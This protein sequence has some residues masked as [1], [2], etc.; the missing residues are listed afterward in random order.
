MK[1][2]VFYFEPAVNP[3]SDNLQQKMDQILRHDSRLNCLSPTRYAEKP[4]AP[5]VK[6]NVVFRH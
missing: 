4:D 1:T 3:V 2:R 5:E 6:G